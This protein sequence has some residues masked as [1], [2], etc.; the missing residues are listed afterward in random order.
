MSVRFWVWWNDSPVRLCLRDSVTLYSRWR[1]EEGWTSV[2][3]QYVRDGDWVVTTRIEDGRD[4]DGRL[5]VVSI[6]RAHVSAL[7][8]RTSVDGLRTP[9]WRRVRAYQ[10]DFT[11]EKAGY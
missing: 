4:C 5:R 1:H 6:A 10:R 9:D 2:E 11:A 3:E 8:A 7:S